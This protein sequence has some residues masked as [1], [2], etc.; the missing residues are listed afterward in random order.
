MGTPECISKRWNIFRL[1]FFPLG[2]WGFRGFDGGLAMAKHC[3]EAKMEYALTGV[4]ELSFGTLNLPGRVKGV[5]GL[6]WYLS[7]MRER[8]AFLPL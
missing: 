2:V 6:E 8:S 1:D 3:T 7:E 5:E 4:D